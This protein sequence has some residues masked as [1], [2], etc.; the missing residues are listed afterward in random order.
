MFLVFALLRLW[1][2]KTF[3]VCLSFYHSKPF[4]MSFEGFHAMTKVELSELIESTCDVTRIFMISESEKLRWVRTICSIFVLPMGRWV[5][6][7]LQNLAKLV[8]WLPQSKRKS[9]DARESDELWHLATMT[10]KENRRFSHLAKRED[11][12]HWTWCSLKCR[13]NRFQSWIAQLRLRRC[14]NGLENYESLLRNLLSAFEVSQFWFWCRWQLF[15]NHKKRR[16]I[17]RIM[18]KVL[19]RTSTE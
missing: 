2:T 7:G 17:D 9:I 13:R 3:E 12:K 4:A 1:F 14:V 5:V 16:V 8:L 10:S 6:H 15:R 18:S 19:T 11:Q